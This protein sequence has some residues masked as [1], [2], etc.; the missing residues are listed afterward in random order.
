MTTLLLAAILHTQATT[1]P[2]NDYANAY[3]QSLASGRPLVVLLGADW[4][5][6]CV[7]MKNSILPKVAKAGGLD[8]V[9]FAYVDMDHQPKLA[10]RLTRGGAIPQLI[11]YEKT[12]KGWKRELL[13][14]AHS[15]KRVTSFVD[16]EPADGEQPREATAVLT[17]R[18]KSVA[19]TD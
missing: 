11:R 15:A 8:N 9:K 13:I 10:A 18:S 6:G 17:S 2:N 1:L 3:E 16:R 7:Q 4:C 19:A 14:G 12:K 5:P